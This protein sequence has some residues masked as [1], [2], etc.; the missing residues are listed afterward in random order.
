MYKYLVVIFALLVNGMALACT[1]SSPTLYGLNSAKPKII[2]SPNKH[3]FIKFVPSRWGKVVTLEDGVHLSSSMI[4]RHKDAQVIAFELLPEGQ[5]KQ[6]W[7]FKYLD[8]DRRFY[9]LKSSFRGNRPTFYLSNNGMNL[10]EMSRA[11][12]RSN[13][14]AVVTYSKGKK[15]K[16]YAPADFGVNELKPG[17]LT[18]HPRVWLKSHRVTRPWVRK[19]HVDIT[20][21]DNLS[22]EIH[23]DSLEIKKAKPEVSK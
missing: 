5:F 13:K 12:T 6:L 2:T 15:V 1:R 22:W 9:N 11:G 4:S 19:A 17:V 20:T 18:C 23:L 3:F 8:V 16:S 14:N 7:S 10:V 21:V